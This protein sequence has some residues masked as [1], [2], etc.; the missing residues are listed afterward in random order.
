MNSLHSPE[1]YDRYLALKVPFLLMVILFYGIR[2]LFIVFL[3]YN[4]SPKF[5]EAFVF[6]QPLANPY[7]V[8]SDLPALLVF[9]AW[10]RRAPRAGKVFRWLWRRGQ[11]LL[12][13]SLLLQLILL[14]FFEGKG[15]WNAYFYDDRER[16]VIVSLGLNLL[17]FYL[18][19]R[20]PL[21]GDVFADFPAV[22]ET[23]GRA[24][25]SWPEKR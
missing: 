10:T 19:W 25:S 3:A 6:M 1:R 21:F 5:A 16:L 9:A 24:G 12:T 13:M 11:V 20:L 23:A 2:H 18:L 14:L 4:P 8:L 22:G 7:F 17:A 15:V